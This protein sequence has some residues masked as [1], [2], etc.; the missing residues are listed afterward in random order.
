VKVIARRRK[1]R[2]GGGGRRG[3]MTRFDT[4]DD[5]T[6]T[7][8]GDAPRAREGK[9]VQ[10]ASIQSRRR[11]ERA[12]AELSEKDASADCFGTDSD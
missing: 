2:R 12:M 8:L 9:A 10:M 4:L 11:S 6:C 7:H 1:R 5:R 3:I